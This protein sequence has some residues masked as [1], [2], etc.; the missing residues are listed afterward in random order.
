MHKTWPDRRKVDKAQAVAMRLDKNMPPALIA[1]HFG[2]TLPTVYRALRE[3]GHP[4]GQAP[5]PIAEPIR[6]ERDPCFR[7]GARG[8]HGCKCSKGK[9]GWHAG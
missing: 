2:V 8:D 6:V 1:Q 3:M 9:L 7:C 4:V 5:L